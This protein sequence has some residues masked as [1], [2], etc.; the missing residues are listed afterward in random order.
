MSEYQ[1]DKP[2]RA[3]LTVDEALYAMNIGR[4]TFY[5]EVKAGRINLVKLGKKTLVPATEP[6]KWL[7]RLAA[8]QPA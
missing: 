1:Y 3:A 5:S 6:A 8:L 2:A 7:E 4:T